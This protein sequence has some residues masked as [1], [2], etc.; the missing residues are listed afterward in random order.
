MILPPPGLSLVSL[1]DCGC[2][3]E[4]DGS[5][6]HAKLSPCGRVWLECDREL[7]TPSWSAMRERLLWKELDEARP[8]AV[9]TQLFTGDPGRYSSP[10]A[11][12]IAAETTAAWRETYRSWAEQQQA[13]P[14]RTVCVDC[15]WVG[16]SDWD[17]PPERVC[18]HENAR[19]L[20][21]GQA[22]PCAHRNHGNC[23]DFEATQ[24]KKAP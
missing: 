22:T 24:G 16:L 19:H 23:P 5:P 13:R 15:R 8:S 7:G 21:S 11:N 17:W 3:I 12:R 9:A 20:V 10:E 18:R 14:T 4:T 6:G 2:K 1:W